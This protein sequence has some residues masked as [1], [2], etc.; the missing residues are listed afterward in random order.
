MAMASWV[1]DGRMGDAPQP[2]EGGSRPSALRTVRLLTTCPAA[3]AAKAAWALPAESR[4]R[5]RGKCC[6]PAMGAG[7]LHCP[8]LKEYISF[9]SSP[10]TVPRRCCSEPPADIALA[11]LFTPQINPASLPPWTVTRLLGFPR[12]RAD[13]HVRE[14]SASARNGR[15]HTPGAGSGA[16][17]LDG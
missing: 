13:S 14:R 7:K 1:T 11:G 5:G 15:I 6:T 4:C 12:S 2:R 8:D 9:A 10:D 16:V 3:E 17:L